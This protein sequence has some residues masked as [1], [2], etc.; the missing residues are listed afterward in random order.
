METNRELDG[1]LE[2]MVV[3]YVARNRAAKILKG[4]LDEAGVGFYPVVDHVTLR[5]MDIDRRA[6]PFLALGLEHEIC[7]VVAEIGPLSI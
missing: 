7:R 4:L 3:E 1:L 6:E 2:R 5:T